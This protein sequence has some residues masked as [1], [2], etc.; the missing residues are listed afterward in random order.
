M[1]GI[2]DAHAQDDRVVTDYDPIIRP[3]TLADAGIMAALARKAY[4][5]YEQ[6]MGKLPGPVFDDYAARA[7]QDGSFVI[8]CGGQLAGLLVV[9][10]KQ[11]KFLIDNLAVDPD[12]QGK[13]MGMKLLAFAE[14]EAVRRGFGEAHLYTHVLMHENI[15]WYARNG[16]VETHRIHE[17]G[18][19]RVYMAKALGALS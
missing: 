11:G 14:A 9:E 10:E 15:G 16:Y 5:L 8:D 19:D 12:F 1:P 17:S 7:A 18:Y 2:G 6:R 13:A 4:A 3:A